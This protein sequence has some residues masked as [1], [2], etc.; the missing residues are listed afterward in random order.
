MSY[1]NQ[2]PS[3][4]LTPFLAAVRE[5]LAKAKEEVFGLCDGSRKWTMCVPVQEQTDSDRVLMVALNDL[6]R[7]LA[8]AEAG[9][10]MVALNDLARLLALAEAGQEMTA[11]FEDMLR[12]LCGRWC[13]ANGP[14]TMGCQRWRA[15]LT[16]YQA[17]VQEATRDG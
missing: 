9:Q 7:L 8:L 12:I 3:T 15:T 10:K 17:A 5:R 14:H 13:T 6:A 4:D 16:R 1:R 2:V 11:Q